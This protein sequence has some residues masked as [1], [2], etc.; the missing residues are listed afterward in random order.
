MKEITAEMINSTELREDILSRCVR[1]ESGCLE[2]QGARDENGYG[3]KGYGDKIYRTHRI[4]KAQDDGRD[5]GEL[6]VRH[7][8]DNPPCVESNHLLTGTDEDNARDREERGRGKKSYTRKTTPEQREEIVRRYN[9]GETNKSALAR[10]FGVSDVMIHKYIKAAH[11][12]A[13]GV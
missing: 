11:T 7:L 13:P 8:C 2:W 1:T 12:A 3:I 9:A 6:L 10:E 4:I 5:P